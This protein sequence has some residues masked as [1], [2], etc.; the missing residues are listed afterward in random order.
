MAKLRDAFSLSRR[1]PQESAPSSPPPATMLLS[2]FLLLA[3]Q[4][5]RAR[6]DVSL[7]RAKRLARGL[8][9]HHIFHEV[10]T[11]V[12]TENEALLEAL[13]TQARTF[14]EREHEETSLTSEPLQVIAA[15]QKRLRV[16]SHVLHQ[17]PCTPAT[18]V[19]RADVIRQY[20]TAESRILC[21]GDDDFVSIALAWIL[22]NEITVLDL[23]PE[24]LSLIEATAVKRQL[25]IR[26]R[27]VDLRRP[28][29]DDLKD[30]YD[31]V[32]TD[33]IYA[34]PEMLVFLSAA[35]ACLRKAPTSYLFTGCSRALAGR[36]WATIE[37]WAEAHHLVPCA[38]LP[39]FNAY[40]KTKRL[41][42]LLNVAERLLLRS[43]LSRACVRLPYLYSDYLILRFREES[44]E[45]TPHRDTPK[46]IKEA[47]DAHHPPCGATLSSDAHRS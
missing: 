22:P 42:L 33:P 11:F 34:V 40:P 9:L 36:S 3:H 24:I 30:S 45:P 29:P 8:G 16:K 35:Y 27:Q 18:S 43:S 6:A 46:L 28:L 13:F 12:E 20:A 31:I 15:L 41:Q 5:W 26:C 17:L 1:G 37:A 10:K 23:D 19:R 39:G 44:R 32:V 2:Q 14:L 38:F 4:P 47:N 7:K 25:R 21:L